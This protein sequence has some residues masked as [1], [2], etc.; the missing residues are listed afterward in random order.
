MNNRAG[1]QAG[2]T[3][4][5]VASDARG[6]VQDDAVA[7]PGQE[8]YRQQR[9]VHRSLE[10]GDQS[11]IDLRDLRR[12]GQHQPPQ[13]TGPVDD[14]VGAE[15]QVRVNPNS[16]TRLQGVSHGSA[17][18]SPDRER[19]RTREP[20]SIRQRSEQQRSIRSNGLRRATRDEHFAVENVGCLAD[21]GGGRS[22]VARRDRSL[23][24]RGDCGKTTS[25]E[26]VDGGTAQILSVH[27]LTV[28]TTVVVTGESRESV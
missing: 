25:C 2:E 13:R 6:E 11:R 9:R 17:G 14:E 12:L 16:P 7:R 3:A 19:Q 26:Q 23:R 10:W 22:G 20:Q 4:T 21:L 1:V 8:L 27:S 24:C 15:R 5:R 28:A 18:V